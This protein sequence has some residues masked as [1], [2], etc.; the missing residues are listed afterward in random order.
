MVNIIGNIDLNAIG[1]EYVPIIG[2]NDI[3]ALSDI[4]NNFDNEELQKTIKEEVHKLTSN[5]PVYN[6]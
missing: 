4:I 6:L 3:F 2:V 5:F 1:D